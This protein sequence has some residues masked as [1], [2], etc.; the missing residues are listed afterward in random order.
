MAEIKGWEL[1]PAQVHQKL[2]VS[3]Q[4][5]ILLDVREPS[6]RQVAAIEPSLHVPMGDVPGQLPHLQAHADDLVVVYCHHGGRSMQVTAFLRQQG[7]EN[8]MNMAGGIDRWARELDPG[9]HRY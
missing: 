3:D 8:V 7:F 9:M 5:M 2:A 6:E 4:D 1:S